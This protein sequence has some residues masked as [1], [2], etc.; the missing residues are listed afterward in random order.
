MKNLKYF[1][2]D[3]FKILKLLDYGF[4]YGIQSFGSLYLSSPENHL[5]PSF[6]YVCADYTNI[7]C[8]CVMLK[9]SFEVPDNT[10]H[11]STVVADRN[12]ITISNEFQETQFIISDILNCHY[13]YTVYPVM[14]IDMYNFWLKNTTLW[15]MPTLKTFN[16][17]S[18]NFPTVCIIQLL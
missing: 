15:I 1:L 17:F 11:Q 7:S 6:Y 12:N 4:W 2:F 16:L 10:R 14:F 8:P 18:Q 5:L 3:P 9:F 13:F